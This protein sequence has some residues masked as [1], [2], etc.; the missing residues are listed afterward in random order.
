[1]ASIRQERRPGSGYASL[2][3]C[4]YEIEAAQK[5]MRREGIQWLDSTSKSIEEIS[6]AL[7]QAVRIDRQVY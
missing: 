1:L 6:A 7:M 4:R 3:N 5:M 2:E